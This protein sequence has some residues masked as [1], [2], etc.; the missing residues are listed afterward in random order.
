MSIH[1]IAEIGI[2]HQGNLKKALRLIDAAKD[3]GCWGVKFQYRQDDF[4]SVN[5]E[6]GS[7]LVRDELKESS[8]DI[9]WVKKIINY[10]K[11][12]D[13]KLGMSFFRIEDLDYFFKK[14]RNI[15]FIKIPSPEFRNIPLIHKAKKHSKQVIVSYGAGNENEIKSAIKKSNFRKSD[16]VMHCISNY[17]VSVGE[18]QMSFL[19]RLK[20]F[21]NCSTGYSSHDDQWEVLIASFQYEINYLERHLCEDK[22]DIGLDISS[23]SDPIEFKKIVNIAKNYNS[24]IASQLRTPNQ[25][26]ILNLRNLG[27]SLFYKND[28]KVGKKINLNDLVEKSPVSGM[29]KDEFLSLSQKK[30]IYNV[31]KGEPIIKS[32]FIKNKKANSG[33]KKFIEKNKISFPVRLHD[34]QRIRERFGTRFFELHLSYDEVKTLSKDKNYLKDNIFENDV[35][36][37]HLPDYID[38]D[39]LIDPFSDDNYIKKE[40]IFHIETTIFKACEIEKLTG[41]KVIIVGSFSVYGQN[42][43]LFY[44]KLNNMIRDYKK[45]RGIQIVAQWLPKKAWYFGGSAILNV[46]CSAEDIKAVKE[47]SIPLCLD[48]SHLILSANYY[49]QDWEKWYKQLYP[50]QKHIHLSDGEGIS[51]E[52]I[53]FGTGDLKN[54][55]NILKSKST[56]VLEVWEGHHNNGEMFYDAIRYLMRFNK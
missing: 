50:L 27:C 14:H 32:N 35:I 16:C 28:F 11:K 23:S 47:I 26:E 46:F 8:F 15:D 12:K 55:N 5:D 34:F 24:I 53:K 42:K 6:M 45:N 1:C 9:K 7:T 3:S 38:K 13:I 43:K 52:G 20:K 44:G 10:C 25:G 40:S 39:N 48:I 29:I 56:K 17:P 21:S 4:F 49:K 19:K 30:L 36:S 22:N 31:K 33:M 18:Q 2:N 51:G 37:I 41:N 54:L